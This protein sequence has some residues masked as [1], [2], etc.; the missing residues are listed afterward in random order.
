MGAHVRFKLP[1]ARVLIYVGQDLL[2]PRPLPSYEHIQ[3]RLSYARLR[4][5]LMSSL[6]LGVAYSFTDF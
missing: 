3:T 4:V 5:H 6:L 1:G 2:L